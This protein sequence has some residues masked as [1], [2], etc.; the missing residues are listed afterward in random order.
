[1]TRKV[2]SRVSQKS[3]KTPPVNIYFRFEEFSFNEADVQDNERVLGTSSVTLP[4]GAEADSEVK[5]S[6]DVSEALEVLERERVT[7]FDVAV[8]GEEEFSTIGEG[9]EFNNLTFDVSIFID[10]N[11]WWTLSETDPSC[12]ADRI[13]IKRSIYSPPYKGGVGGRVLHLLIYSRTSN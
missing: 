1:M 10:Q 9:A 7:D 11:G 2:S 5:A 3:W 12:H 4:V 6:I 13:P 8:Q